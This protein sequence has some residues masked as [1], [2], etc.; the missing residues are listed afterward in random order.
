MFIVLQLAIF[1]M[2]RHTISI[3]S[4]GHAHNPYVLYYVSINTR[5][6]NLIFNNVAHT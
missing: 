6:K 3:V 1:L 2:L 5:R 4:L